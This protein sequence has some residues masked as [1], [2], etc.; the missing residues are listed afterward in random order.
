MNMKKF[1]YFTVLSIFILV[2]M[3]AWMG[4]KSS[5]YDWELMKVKKVP[6]GEVRSFFSRQTRSLDKFDIKAVTL[7]PGQEGN[8]YQTDDGFDEL[9]IVKEGEI[10]INVNGEESL[11]GEGSVVVVPEVS[12]IYITSPSGLK[13]VYYMIGFKPPKFKAEPDTS[14]FA[15]LGEDPHPAFVDWKDVAI[16]PSE[17]GGR[18]N[19]IQ[20][21]TGLLKELEIHVTIL[22][23]GKTSHA[24]HTHTD[25]EIILVKKGF[26]E[27]NISGKNFRVGPGSVIFLSNDDPHGIRNAGTGECEYFAIRWLINP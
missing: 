16:V 7:N 13:A 8:G 25:E 3:A 12:E 2:S 24:P 10:N 6:T 18:R 26:V 9:I 5:V 20:Q 15:F 4:M 11:L 14:V 27:E 19:F 21:K 23:E 17:N 22:K 1:F